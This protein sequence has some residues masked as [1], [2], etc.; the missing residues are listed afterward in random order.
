MSS[1]QGLAFARLADTTHAG[2]TF[3]SI[4]T[5]MFS[6]NLPLGIAVWL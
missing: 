1:A 3:F 6:T 5:N 2:D 4:C